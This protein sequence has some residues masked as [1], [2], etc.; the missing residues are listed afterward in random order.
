MRE[1]VRPVHDFEHSNHQLPAHPESQ[2]A[3]FETRAISSSSL[4]SKSVRIGIVRLPPAE[5]KLNRGA[6]SLEG[7]S[8]YLVDGGSPAR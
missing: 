1:D 6:F 8:R 2:R 3:F 7:L 4:E 5:N